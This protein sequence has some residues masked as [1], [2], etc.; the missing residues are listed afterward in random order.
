M[1]AISPDASLNDVERMY[2]NGTV[3]WDDL[4]TYIRAWNA[5]PHFTQAV[6][7]DGKIRNFDPEQLAAPTHLFAL[8]GVKA[9]MVAFVCKNDKGY[10]VGWI[11]DEA[12]HPY[13]L[14]NATDDRNR[15]LDIAS[16]IASNHNRRVRE[17]RLHPAGVPH[18]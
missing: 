11:R 12:G 6:Y 7:A 15:A 9:P 18:G 17:G 16:R 14:T 2:N 1:S 13:P 3:S 10:W 4:V 8:F 5:G